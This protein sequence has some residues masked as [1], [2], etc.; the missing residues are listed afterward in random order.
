MAFSWNPL[1]WFSPPQIVADEQFVLSL[2][3]KVVR[4]E[5]V[6]ITDL[7]AGYAWIGQNGP[8]IIS[9]ISAIMQVVVAF[10]GASNPTVAAAVAAVNVATTALNT[11]VVAQNTGLGV[12]NALVDAYK[13][14][15]AL[16]G[17]H[18]AA[19]A[20]VTTPKAA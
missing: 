7:N 3:G 16:Q 18:V 6:A 8:G 5:Q 13:A 12:A 10:A 15:K 17:A 14:L 1:Q 2:V 9:T 11:L 20:V 19:V 4:A